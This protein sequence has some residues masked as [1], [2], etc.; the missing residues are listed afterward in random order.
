MANFLNPWLELIHSHMHTHTQG[1]IHKNKITVDFWFDV[2]FFD[3]SQLNFNASLLRK[4]TRL[5]WLKHTQAEADMWD[6]V[7]WQPAGCQ[8]LIN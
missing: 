3:E 5:N 2:I 1:Q 6:K 7:T 8:V 4:L